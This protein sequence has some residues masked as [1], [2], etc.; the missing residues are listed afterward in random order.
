MLGRPHPKSSMIET[1]TRTAMTSSSPPPSADGNA[2]LKPGD[3]VSVN[4][5]ADLL[6]LLQEGHG[7]WNPKMEEVIGKPGEVH[8][9]TERGDVRVKYVI[10]GAETI[11]MFHPGALSKVTSKKLRIF[12]KR[13]FSLCVGCR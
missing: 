10:D 8:R 12:F 3:L 1:K 13:F 6:R 5:E 7:G 4:L 9:V 2:G 11:W